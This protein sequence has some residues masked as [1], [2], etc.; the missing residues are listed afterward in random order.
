MTMQG[1]TDDD[2]EMA[3]MNRIGDDIDPKKFQLFFQRVENEFL[4]VLHGLDKPILDFHRRPHRRPEG[5]AL[6]MLVAH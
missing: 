6:D 3:A 5:L 2:A 4:Q 1:H